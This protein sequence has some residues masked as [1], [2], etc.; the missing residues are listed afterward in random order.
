MLDSRIW[1]L[2]SSMHVFW[3]PRSRIDF[4]EARFHNSG[5]KIQNCDVILL[6]K[7]SVWNLGSRIHVPDDAHKHAGL[8]KLVHN[9]G[10]AHVGV[11]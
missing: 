4:P 6:Q 10:H 1:N 2:D 11:N 3:S 8:Q 5:S 7:P 9:D